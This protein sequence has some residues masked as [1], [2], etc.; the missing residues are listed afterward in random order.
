MKYIKA[1]V[2]WAYSNFGLCTDHQSLY[3][4]SFLISQLNII[5]LSEILYTLLC[6]KLPV[7]Y[8]QILIYVLYSNTVIW[9][10]SS[11]LIFVYKSMEIRN[12]LCANAWINLG[13]VGGVGVGDGVVG[14]EGRGYWSSRYTDTRKHFVRAG[15][16]YMD[17]K[18]NRVWFVLGPVRIC[19]KTKLC[20][21]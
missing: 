3:S 17:Q 12:S 7:V 16:W 14:G 21:V 1:M 18:L 15:T 2:E 13:I 11:H 8:L 19:C 6:S 10:G 9:T 4:F 20:W 5:K